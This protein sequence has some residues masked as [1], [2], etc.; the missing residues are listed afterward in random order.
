MEDKICP[1]RTIAINENA[2]CLTSNC[3][4][5]VDSKCAMV[6]ITEQL[7]NIYTSK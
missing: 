2:T 7:Y 3:A 4:W 1:L 5:W 6:S